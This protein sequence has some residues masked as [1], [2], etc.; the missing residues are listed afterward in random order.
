MQS[1]SLPEKPWERPPAPQKTSMT[2]ATG[3]RAPCDCESSAGPPTWSLESLGL[4]SDM[5]LETGIMF[6]GLNL[7]PPTS[8]HNPKLILESFDL[9][10]G[11]RRRKAYAASVLFWGKSHRVASRSGRFK[12]WV[13]LSR[14]IQ[15]FLGTC[16]VPKARLA[17]P[18]V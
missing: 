16:L 2:L 17:S 15:I 18:L 10:L 1:R 7:A 8:N 5:A 9:T 6:A 12:F 4:F 14:S 11:W 13:N 3:F